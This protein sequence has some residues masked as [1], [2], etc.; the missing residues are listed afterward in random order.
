MCQ[1]AW[2]DNRHWPN[3]LLA[4]CHTVAVAIIFKQLAFSSDTGLNQTVIFRVT[5]ME[6]FGVGYD[7]IKDDH[8]TQSARSTTD[9][10]ALSGLAF[11]YSNKHT[12]V[13]SAT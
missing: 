9:N 12:H 13:S 10:R 3:G 2:L 6:C 1:P 5:S 4:L 8:E 11:K 7:K